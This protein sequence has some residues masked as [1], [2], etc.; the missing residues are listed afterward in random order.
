MV[1]GKEKAKTIISFNR[2]DE[3]RHFSAKKTPPSISSNLTLSYRLNCFRRSFQI[4]E[5]FTQTKAKQCLSFTYGKQKWVEHVTLQMFSLHFLFKDCYCCRFLRDERRSSPLFTKHI[6]Y[7]KVTG[8]L[9]IWFA[10]IFAEPMHW[11]TSVFSGHLRLFIWKYKWV[12]CSTAMLATKRWAGVAPEL[13]LRESITCMGQNMH[14]KASSLTLSPK[15]DFTKV[16]NTDTK[17]WC[18][19]E[20]KKNTKNH[21][22]YRLQQKFSCAETPNKRNWCSRRNVEFT[23][24]ILLAISILIIWYTCQWYIHNIS[25]PVFRWAPC[26]GLLDLC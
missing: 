13:T 22:C 16:Q 11:D 14:A 15:E 21:H 3:T 2:E 17:D 5:V 6:N 18:P 26:I 9:H 1:H 23:V 12:K 7:R 8:I 19:P 25:T 4:V 10:L 20:I 24:R